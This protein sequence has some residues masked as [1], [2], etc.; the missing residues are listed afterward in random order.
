MLLTLKKIS[1]NSPLK[2]FSLL[3]F[4]L[5]NTQHVH[6]GNT[7]MDVIGDW[8][9][10]LEMQGVVLPL[11]FNIFNKQ[12]NLQGTMDSP[13][14][15]AFDIPLV[16]NIQDQQITLTQ[17]QLGIQY[18]GYIDKE[19][20]TGKFTQAD[21]VAKLTLTRSKLKTFNISNR[22]QTPVPPFSYTQEEVKFFHPIDRHRLSGTLS[23]PTSNKKYP[24]IILLS[25]SGQQDRD[26][27]LFGH[28]PFL[29]IADYLTR[30]GFAVL[31]YDDR[32]I[33]QSE[34]NLSHATSLDFADDGLA[35]VNFLRHHEYIDSHRIGLLGHSEGSM[36]AQLMAAQDQNIAFI[37]SL[38]GPG[39]NGVT[40]YGK[41]LYMLAKGANGDEKILGFERFLAF[42][43]AASE[44][45]SSAQLKSLFFEIHPT[46][47]TKKFQQTLAILAS[48]WFQYFLK[49]NPATTLPNVKCPILAVHGSID[50]QLESSSNL[51][52]IESILT[53]SAHLDFEIKEFKNLNHLFQQAVTGLPE[54]Y[55]FIEETLSLEVLIY[56]TDWLTQRFL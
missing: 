42:S 38:A 2:L 33:G 8:E 44:D 34:G 22:P 47:D 30:A 39:L 27:T 7:Q 45:I 11:V 28:K 6:A 13:A 31:R 51:A 49:F 56:I 36:I 52:A 55:P 48:P 37:L 5:I 3:L 29:V 20:I 26:Y 43:E 41:Q 53:K 4:C 24:A 17:I 16:I 25:G 18:I 40:V 14:Q 12:E 1:P 46:A 21:Q 19:K 35:A 23:Y 15:N 50:R 9:G 10:I 54:E 32:G